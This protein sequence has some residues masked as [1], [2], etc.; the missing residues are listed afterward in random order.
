ML[1]R[2]RNGVLRSIL[3][4]KEPAQVSQVAAA[5]AA[6]I[7]QP[8]AGVNELGGVA[9]AGVGGVAANG[10]G[11]GAM[12]GI[13]NEPARK[14][15]AGAGDETESRKTK[16]VKFVQPIEQFVGP[17][18]ELYGPFEAEARAYLPTQI[19]DILIGEGRAV[20]IEDE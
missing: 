9:T 5:T 11:T 7:C 6:S 17:E 2:F 3:E 20:E 4:L 10:L 8:A 13:A 18:L 1:D 12:S 19:A 16:F 14:E 15:L